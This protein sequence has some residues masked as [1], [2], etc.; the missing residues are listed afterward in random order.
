MAILHTKFL[1]HWTG[2]DFHCPIET[3]DDNIRQKYVDRLT[4]TLTNGFLMQKNEEKAERIYDVDGGWIQGAIART[5]FTEIKLSLAK[6]HAQTYGSLGIGVDREYVIS[7]Y[8]N[9]VFYVMNGDHSN[10]GVCAR[11]VRDYLEQNSNEILAEFNTLLGYFKKTAE[12]NADDLQ[13]YDELEWRITHLTRLEQEGSVVAQDK[14]NHIY[15]IRLSKQDVRVIVFPDE[16]TKTWALNSPN[17]TEQIDR[18][19]CVTIDDCENF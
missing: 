10:I 14:A 17:I 15:R 18:P 3:L 6:K 11:K 4:N 8:G 13:Y 19:I 7:R 5:C 16:R 9:P 1:V 2:R 12:Q